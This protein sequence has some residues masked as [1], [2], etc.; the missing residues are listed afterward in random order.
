MVLHDTGDINDI[1]R[2]YFTNA[3]TSSKH[4]QLP[5][6]LAVTN[7]ITKAGTTSN[8]PIKTVKDL[9][10]EETCTPITL[11]SVRQAL[12][13]VQ[14]LAEMQGQISIVFTLE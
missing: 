11:E 7:A 13:A 10:E 2:R 3:V 4:E 9:D 6:K 14:Q 5:T 12:E 8:N 1:R